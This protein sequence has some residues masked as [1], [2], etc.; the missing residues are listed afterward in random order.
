MVL[1]FVTVVLVLLLASP[2]SAA[3]V[4][5]NPGLVGL[6]VT[7]SHLVNLES[8]DGVEWIY[9]LADGTLANGFYNPIDHVPSLEGVPFKTF[10]GVWNAILNGGSFVILTDA[11]TGQTGQMFSMYCGER[12]IV[13][14]VATGQQ[15]TYSAEWITGVN[16]IEATFN[17]LTHV[18]LDQVRALAADQVMLSGWWHEIGNDAQAMFTIDIGPGLDVEDLVFWQHYTV[19]GED[20]WAMF[21]PEVY[22]YDDGRLSFI[23]GNLGIYDGFVVAIRDPSYIPEP[24][25]LALLA[26][27]GM[28]LMGRQ[29]RIR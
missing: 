10:G 27:G 18:E 20:R 2:V 14:D 3:V 23:S 29:R 19:D 12:A 28:V 1:S 21:T 9:M 11:Q 5:S 13:T 8:L 22:T 6:K 26:A 25:T 15:L 7:G 4:V 16:R 24:A 17:V